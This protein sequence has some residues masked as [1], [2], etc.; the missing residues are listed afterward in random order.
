MYAGV[1]R[2]DITPPVGISM[3]GYYIREGVS[4]GIER[5]LTATAFVLTDGETKVVIVAC[6][7]LFI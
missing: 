3:V 1:T 4:T 7:L 5:P 2:V 6:D